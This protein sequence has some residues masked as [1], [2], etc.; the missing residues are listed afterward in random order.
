[1]DAPPGRKLQAEHL[2]QRLQRLAPAP[3]GGQRLGQVPGDRRRHLPGQAQLPGPGQPVQPRLDGQLVAAAP[4]QHMAGGQ[5]R[6]RLELTVADPHRLIPRAVQ[7]GEGVLAAERAH[8]GQQHLRLGLA[9]LVAQLAGQGAHLPG[10]PCRL[11]MPVLTPER[12][13]H[14]RHDLRAQSAR[15]GRQPQRLPQVIQLPGQQQL[16]PQ[17]R[18]PQQRRC[19]PFPV[20]GAVARPVQRRQPRLH[21]RQPPLCLPRPPRR[22]RP[23]HQHPDVIGTGPRGG[24]GHLIPQ[25]EHLFQHLQ[26]LCVRERRPRLAGRPPRRLQRQR[27]LSGNSPVPRHRHRGL[28]PGRGSQG[29]SEPPVRLRPLA[30]QQ[31]FQHRLADQLMPEGVPVAVADQHV[32][33]HR[34]PNRRGQR[35]ILPR[36]HRGQQPVPGTGPAHRRGPQQLLGRL[37]QVLDRPERPRQGGADRPVPVHQR[38][39]EQRIPPAAPPHRVEHRRRRRPPQDP[40][41]LRTHLPPRKPPQLQPGHPVHPL[42]PGQQRPQR[43]GPVQVVGPERHHRQNRG[44]PQ[45]ADQEA[46]QVTGGRVG[47]VHV[48]DDQQHRLPLGQPLEQREQQLEQ[49]RPG[50]RRVRAR[51]QRPEL[52][53]QPG[54]LA[55]RL[56]RQQRGHLRGAPLPHQLAQRRPERRVRQARRAFR[57][58]VTIMMPNGPSY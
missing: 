4:L 23:Q 24:V 17:S 40:L 56:P 6:P 2:L 26:P 38:L 48:L 34:G 47:P 46:Q 33:R 27:G 53:Q 52:R 10:E 45:V 42:Q 50:R 25:L 49:P 9:L 7:R 37:G 14:L 28:G 41:Q 30:R 32:R 13:T 44:L 39:G 58:Y 19:D 36:R 35:S 20:A 16:P 1:M 15:R 21:Q 43:V 3:R 31:L 51:R 8:R 54:Q 11:L 57:R 29:E 55:S 12:P 22:V 18:P 5:V